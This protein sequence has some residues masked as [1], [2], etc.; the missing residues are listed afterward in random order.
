LEASLGRLPQQAV[1]RAPGSTW[2]SR[3]VK[4]LVGDINLSVF[5]LPQ[6]GQAIS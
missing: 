2:P 1:S 4:L 5:Q 3:P 6:D